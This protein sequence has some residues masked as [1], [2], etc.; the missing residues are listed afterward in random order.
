M[1]RRSEA[2]PAEPV[3]TFGPIAK[4]IGAAAQIDRIG[5]EL[6]GDGALVVETVE[7]ARFSDEPRAA[8]IGVL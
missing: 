8:T 4:K 1:Y 7:A 2:V 3:V 6:A 5:C